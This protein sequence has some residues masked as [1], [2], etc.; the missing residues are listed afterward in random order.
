MEVG[1]ASRLNRTAD[2]DHRAARVLP[3][4]RR[5]RMLRWATRATG[6][7]RNPRTFSTGV[8]KRG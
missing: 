8:V 3:G 5:G 7:F 2:L 6:R 1:W 4:H